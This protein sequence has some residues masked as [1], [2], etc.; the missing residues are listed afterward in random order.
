MPKVFNWNDTNKHAKKSSEFSQN[1]AIALELKILLNSSQAN[2]PLLLKILLMRNSALS[3]VIF[4]HLINFIPTSD[5][6]KPALQQ[7]FMNQKQNSKK[8]NGFICGK[9]CNSVA[10]WI[11][12]E[13]GLF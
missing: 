5:C 6:F 9:E 7:P 2:W 8:C 13:N 11:R 3:S 1:T 10:E 12:G 4:Q